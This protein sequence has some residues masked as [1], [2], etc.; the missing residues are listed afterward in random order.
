MVGEG[1]SAP[2]PIGKEGLVGLQ[3]VGA[4]DEGR[5]LGGLELR[6]QSVGHGVV[7]EGGGMQG[8]SGLCLCAGSCERQADVMYI[9]S[10]GRSDYSVADPCLAR[11]G[12]QEL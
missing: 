1:S 11:R 8:F 5:D 12:V 2:T 3:L 9:V 10:T 6:G 7:G 4:L